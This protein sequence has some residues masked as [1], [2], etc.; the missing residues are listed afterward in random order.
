MA[1]APG[2]E[3]HAM[4]GSLPHAITFDM[5]HVICKNIPHDHVVCSLALWYA[6][7]TMWYACSKPQKTSI[8]DIG[9]S[10]MIIKTM[11]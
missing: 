3:H 9:R 6:Y 1:L 5:C 11:A 4:F 7:F 2:V 10:V 8:Y